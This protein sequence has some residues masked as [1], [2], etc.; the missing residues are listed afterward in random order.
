MKSDVMKYLLEADD[1]E[2]LGSN[3][4]LIVTKKQNILLNEISEEI[5][6]ECY[7]TFGKKFRKNG[8]KDSKY[9]KVIWSDNEIEYLKKTYLR[10]NLDEIASQIN[11][12]KYQI[13]LMLVK[14][15]LLVKREWS[16][17]ELEFL[18]NNI[19]ESTIWLAGELNR[20]VAS[21]KSKKKVLKNLDKYKTKN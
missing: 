17:L 16:E 6:D 15:K 1:I 11:K 13:N 8:R 7:E 14:L 9:L 19:E 20:S 2:A 21:I 12:S 10:K 5:I 4:L 18:K 3:R